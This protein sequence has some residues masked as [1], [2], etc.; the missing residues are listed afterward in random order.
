M[1][2]EPA[3]LRDLPT[4]TLAEAR[5]DLPKLANL[6]HYTGQITLLTR[7]GKPWA[8][9][10]PLSAARADEPHPPGEDISDLAERLAALGGS[11]A[12]TSD[13]VAALREVREEGDT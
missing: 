4:A 10:A 5:A 9:I 12:T 13:I 6:A 7:Y 3:N 1:N 11:T 8:V 2:T